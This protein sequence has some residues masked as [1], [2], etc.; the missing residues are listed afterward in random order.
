[1][2]SDCVSI[3]K[4]LYIELEE[5]EGFSFRN[6]FQDRRLQALDQH[7]NSAFLF[8]IANILQFQIC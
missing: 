6:Q 1:M 7:F 5:Y 2:Q 4:L 3:V 8:V